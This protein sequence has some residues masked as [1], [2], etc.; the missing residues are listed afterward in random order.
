MQQIR[1]A[2]VEDHTFCRQGIVQWI[3]RQPELT[4][5]G[6]AGTLADARTLIEATR[7]DVVLLDLML[8]DGD[9]LDL[10]QELAA[11]YPKVR[12]LVMSQKDERLYATRA[13]R[14]GARGYLMKSEAV[15]LVKVAIQ[16]VFQG[17]VY[18]SFDSSNSLLQKLFPDPLSTTGALSALSNRELQVFELLGQGLSSGQISESLGISPKTVETYKD[19]VKS[20]LQIKNSAALI[21]SATNWV[22]TGTLA[23]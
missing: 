2:V 20:K 21:N 4:C 5:C 6:D 16:T 15:D 19:L 14:S 18:L 12:F 22:K 7:P 8:A 10:L 17:Q 3:N 11:A 23:Q 9:G 1:V 13:L